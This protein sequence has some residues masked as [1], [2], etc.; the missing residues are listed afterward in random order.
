MDGSE[1]YDTAAR[2]CESDTRLTT[3]GAAMN[4][5]AMPKTRMN[6]R[7]TFLLTVLL[8]M[9]GLR[10]TSQPVPITILVDEHGEIPCDDTLGRIDV[11]FSELRNNPTNSGLVVISGMPENKHRILFRQTIIQHQIQWRQ[12]DASRIRFLRS[13]S[14]ETKVQFWRIPPGADT[15]DIKDLD[16]SY[17]IPRTVQP[18]LMGEE[19][20]LGDQIC[21]EVDDGEIFAKFLKENPSARGNIVVRDNSPGQAR[22]K[23]SAFVRRFSRKYGISP[24]RLRSFAAKLMY[25]P[26]HDEA[27][28][29]YWYL[30]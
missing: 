10:A 30:P 4:G 12:F 17:T 26:N 20:K 23:A 8:L 19:T 25:P 3:Q 21:P 29:E 13:R 11:F 2:L 5:V 6:L 18:F 1:G 24:V 9:P 28:I 27:V 7:R 14:E 16:M 22:G 15:P